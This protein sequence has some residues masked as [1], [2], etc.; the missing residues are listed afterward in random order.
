MR[1]ISFFS[2]LGVQRQPPARQFS[3]SA[4]YSHPHPVTWAGNLSKTFPVDG[5]YNVQ[6]QHTEKGRPLLHSGTRKP[7]TLENHN[8]PYL[9]QA[10]MAFVRYGL[11]LHLRNSLRC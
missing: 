11:R 4:S 2:A 3:Y 8:Y 1:P 10:F 6:N 7:T 5:L 9:S